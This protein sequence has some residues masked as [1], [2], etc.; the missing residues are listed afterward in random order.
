M[1][2]SFLYRH[3]AELCSEMAAAAKS[4]EIREQWIELAGYWKQKSEGVDAPRPGALI[5]HE[6]PAPPDIAASPEKAKPAQVQRVVSVPN[7]APAF[8]PQEPRPSSIK[9][10]TPPDPSQQ[11]FSGEL[12]DIW[13][14]AIAD[15]LSK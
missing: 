14:K 9:N 3:H 1:T 13:T 7:L 4:V 6:P 12:E 15:I 10:P 5:K 8:V 2:L 11:V